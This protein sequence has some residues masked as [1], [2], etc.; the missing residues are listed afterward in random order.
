MKNKIFILTIGLAAIIGAITFTSCG[1][2]FLDITPTNAVSSSSIWTSSNLADRA[3]NGIYAHIYYEYRMN[4]WTTALWDTYSEIMDEDINWV[5][6]R[7]PILTG[8]A[9]ASSSV[10]QVWWKRFYEGVSRCNDVIANISQV[11]DMSD[12]IKARDIAEAK[13]LRA[14][15]YYRLNVLWQGVPIYLENVGVDEATKGRSSAE[16]VF[17]QIIADCTD[18]INEPNL[19]D[20]YEP[21][22]SDWGRV[23]KSCAYMLRAK[24]Y[25]WLK[26]WANAEA[27]FKKITTMGFELFD[28]Y[29]N[30]F[31]EQNEK[32][33][34]YIFPY[35]YMEPD[36]GTFFSWS[37]GNRCT[38]GYSWNNY[39]P[40]PAFVD[41]Y[42]NIDGSK[43][44]IDDVLPGYSSMTPVQ[45]IVFYLRDNMTDEEIQ[46]ETAIGAD[47][48]KY[49]PTGNEA[50]IKKVYENRDPRLNWNFI[51]PYSTYLGGGTGVEYTYTLRWPYR[52]YDAAEPFDIRTDTNDRFYYLWRKFVFRGR[53]HTD[54]TNSPIDYPTFRYAEVLLGLAEALNEQ[55][56]TDEAIP[57]IN[58]VRKRAGVAELNSNEYTMVSG[59][60]DLRERIQNEYGWELCGENITYFNELRWGNWYQ[61]KFVESNGMTEIW[62]TKKY[63]LTW[64][65]DFCWKWAIP[66]AEIEKN[67]N[68]TQN[69]GWY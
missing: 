28:D 57:Y 30:L 31:T 47:M 54:Q 12:E 58:Q 16:E 63:T 52:G 7:A 68:I 3:V 49:L 46:N 36:L 59:Q 5:N 21:S 67:P 64:I 4:P 45:R 15:E 42:E 27:D 23:S 6:N 18:A 34:E 39:L 26:D 19:P 43:F 11:P 69:E 10:F 2:D 1:S 38:T 20:R 56:K 8:S 14:W 33:N 25:L 51:V 22:S 65:G 13:F 24:A 48:S 50:R 9:T 60:D 53:E 62:G 17:N 32:N 41:S 40:N 55:G 29:Y 37:F 35:Q 61:K 66:Q 44:N